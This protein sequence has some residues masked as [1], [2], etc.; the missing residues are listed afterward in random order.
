MKGETI[1]KP[2]FQGKDAKQK[3][4][5]NEQIRDREVRVISADGE[6][7]GIMS[8]QEALRI[9]DEN[10]LDLVKI[11]PNATPP[12]CKIM[13]YGK[14]IFDLAKREKEAKKNQK[15]IEIKE[16]QLSV[17]IDVGDVNTKAKHCKKFL[18]K[19][20]KVKVAI[21]L[22]GR[23]MAH[24]NLAYDVLNNFF[25]IVKDYAVMEKRPLMEGRNITMM[26]APVKA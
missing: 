13:N 10:E 12:V 26:L 23:Q 1:I 14:Y 22:R 11:S 4:Q 8:A 25:E 20:N 24:Q 21:R 19:G 3:F 15:V 2:D 17:T 16:I 7:L 18:E 5:I 6:Q 9:A